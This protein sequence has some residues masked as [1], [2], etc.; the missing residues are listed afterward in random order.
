MAL[1]IFDIIF[2]VSGAGDAVQALKNI[3]TEAKSTADSLDNTKVSAVNFGA[4]L[5]GL[6]AGAAVAGF[7]KGAIDAAVSFDSMQRALANCRFYRRTK[8]TDGPSA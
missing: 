7:A 6:L 5:K 3:K 1:G 2:K 4:Q 8:C